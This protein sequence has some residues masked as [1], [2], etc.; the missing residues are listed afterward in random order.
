MVQSFRIPL[1][2]PVVIVPL[3]LKSLMVADV[4]V[5]KP[6]LPDDEIVPLLVK[7]VLVAFAKPTASEVPSIVTPE[8]IVTLEP[9]PS[10][11]RSVQLFEKF[12]VEPETSVQFP[13]NT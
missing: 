8:L 6:R 2:P 5:R 9:S 1:L 13:D 12:S 3:L 4:V 11:S 10:I 7:V